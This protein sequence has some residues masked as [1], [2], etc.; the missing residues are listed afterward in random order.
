MRTALNRI[1]RTD[2]K[3]TSA[4]VVTIGNFDGIHIGHR[5]VLEQLCT[6]RD[7]ST[8][9]E[10]I[11]LS[12]Y[13]HPITVLKP[14]VTI[15]SISS[16]R[17]KMSL[18]SA[19]GVNRLTLIHFTK[20]LSE[21]S[22]A[23]FIDTFVIKICNAK[24]LVLG[25]D[26]AL[27]RNREGDINFIKSYC[28]KI[29]LA[30]SVVDTLMV[31]GQKISSR[32]IRTAIVSGD[33][34]KAK[35]LLGRSYSVD[36]KVINGDKRGRTLG[37]KT[38]NVDTDNLLLPPNGVYVCR[39]YLKEQLLHGVA[40]I[41]IRPTFRAD[42]NVTTEVHLLDFVGSDFYHEH[43]RVEFIVKIRDEMK[44]QSVENLKEQ[45]AKDITK[46]REVLTI[47]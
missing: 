35:T 29:G 41:G 6:A 21:L 28:S 5:A 32:D 23:Q 31:N 4:S 18:L 22:A 39:V 30:V 7:Q 40:N 2:S 44:F 33:L 26:T 36:G 42:L 12:L 47:E 10:A 3:L 20:A 34:K 27:G 16:L 25:P 19:L 38:A 37:Y 14:E 9:N 13:P 24:Q 11:V 15:Q 43:M 1:K 45:I 46:A 8:L 17:E